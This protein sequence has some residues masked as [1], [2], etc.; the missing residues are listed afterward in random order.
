[1]TSFTQPANAHTPAPGV[2]L[3]SL[4]APAPSGA[5]VLVKL[6]QI[7]PS[8]FNPRKEFPKDEIAELAE[9]IKAQGLLE[10][11][12]VRVKP[13]KQAERYELMGGERRLR[14]LKLIGADA[15]MCMVRNADDAT[16][17]AI[18]IVENLQRQDLGP[19]EEAEAF[20]KLQ[21]QDPKTWTAQ[22][23]AKAVGKTDRFVQQRIAIAKNLTSPLKKMFDKGEINVEIARTLAPLPA[24]LQAK[25]QDSYGVRENSASDVRR[26]IYSAAIPLNHAAF[27]TALYTG[28]LL[29]E[30]DKK[31]CLNIDQF[32]QLQ[33]VEARKAL[34]KLKAEWPKAQ[35]IDHEDAKAWQWADTT[36]PAFDGIYNRSDRTK[37]DKYRVPK[38]KCTAVVFVANDGRIRIAEGV[39]TRAAID[40]AARVRQESSPAHRRSV[41]AGKSTTESKAQKAAREK[42]NADLST[43][44]RKDELTRQRLHLL[45]LISD[46]YPSLSGTV[47]LK[48]VPAELKKYVGTFSYTQETAAAAWAAVTKLSPA[49]VR[50]TI[51]ELMAGMVTWDQF[52]WENCP[53]FEAT[54]A[55]SLKV[56]IPLAPAAIATQQN[57]EAAPKAKAKKSAAK[58]KG[59]KK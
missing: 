50:N 49:V 36:Y 52:D 27:D 25:V 59:G 28:E 24:S 56:F 38:E 54:V 33:T 5:A 58:K 30:G 43:A 34:E 48:A 11:L 46:D 6:A 45:Q 53:A 40:A 23:I 3:S 21:A 55:A 22:A 14:A 57:T 1:M 7:D 37:P 18:Q 17:M 47:D 15:A 13:G 39:C 32:R 16:A 4:P 8:P 26:A 35:L 42:F 10:P 31:L 12:V 29:E 20:A 9:S 44:I 2:P 41:A 19:L 51:A